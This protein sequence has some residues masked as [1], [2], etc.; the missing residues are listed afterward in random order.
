MLSQLVDLASTK[1]FASGDVIL[2]QDVRAESLF[3]VLRGTVLFERTFIE[4]DAKVS[5]VHC[6]FPSS[7]DSLS[8]RGSIDHSLQ[9]WKKSRNIYGGDRAN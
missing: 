6:Y 9:R 4:G 1:E 5:H 2:E 7:A 3:I 8:R